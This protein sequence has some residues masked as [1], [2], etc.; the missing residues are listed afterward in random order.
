MGVVIALGMN[1]LTHTS[2]TLSMRRLYNKACAIALILSANSY[3][4]ELMS[5][6]G[7]SASKR[8]SLA[9]NWILSKLA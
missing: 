2:K 5:G 3:T 6:K 4:T 7:D 9:L 8:S 1:E